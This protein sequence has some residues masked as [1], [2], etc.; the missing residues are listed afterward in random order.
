MVK[1]G[2]KFLVIASVSIGL[3]SVVVGSKAEDTP[4]SKPHYYDDAVT[5]PPDTPVVTKEDLPY[6]FND[7]NGTQPVYDDN[8]G[9]YLS[10]P[11]N[12]KTET[13]Y[14]PKTGNY[15]VTQ[16][17]GDMNY[18]PET[19]V[20]FQDYQDAL[21]KKAVKDHWKS[22]IKA[23]DLNNQN[24]KGIIPKLTV[25]SE[26]FD[27]IFGGNTVDIK[28]T[29]TAELIFALNRNK[30]LNPAIPQ[31]QQKVTN[32]DFN[33]RIQL[34]LIGKIGDKLKI[35]TNYNT[36]ASFDWENQM[37][38]E[39]TGYE[40]EII[41][42]IEAGNVSLPLN[43]TLITGS[44]S[45]FGVKMQLQFG[46]LTA[47]TIFSQQRGK[48][49]EV[50]VQGGSQIQN[51]TVTGD[52]YEVNKH[53]FLG[54][55]FRDNYDD[56]MKTLP[57][58]STPIIITKAEVYI[59][60]QTGS[61]ENVRS[62][63][64]F[65][66][67]GEDSA[68]ANPTMI[69]PNCQT[70]SNYLVVDSPGVV[71][72]NGANSLYSIISSTLA[73]A[74]MPA[75]TSTTT[76]QINSSL[77]SNAV[78]P[79]NCNSNSGFMESSRHYEYVTNARRLNPSEYSINTRLGFIS[80]NQSINNDVAVAVAYQYTYNGKTYQV[81][82][83]S[84]QFTTGPLYL[85]LLKG[86]LTNPKYIT[87]DL[88]MKNVYSIGA[89]NLNPQ[90]FK[91]DI[92]YNNIETGVDV[93]YIPA[94]AINGKLLLQVMDLDKLSVNGDKYSDGV[95]DFVKDYTINPV[96][97]RVYLSSKEPFG[98]NLREKF[99]ASDFPAA[100][101]YIFQYLYDS[102]RT[103]AQQFPERN[104]FKLKGQY[105]SA[106]G[107]EISL[108]ALNIPQGAVSVTANGQKLVENQDYTVD[109]TLGRVK[110]INESILNSGAN[111]KVSTESNSL[112]NV[113]QKSLFGTRLDYKVNK[114]LILG[115]TLL[116]LN[117]KPVTQK[118]T[119]GDE[120]VSN[121]IWG[122]DYN[123]R[124]DAP[125]L[126]RLVD[127]IPLI[128]TK[129]M[130][131]IVTQGEFAQLIPGNAKA[132]G[133]NGTS[134]VDDFEGS[135][136][137]IDIKSPQ[138]WT[139]AS[140]P[141][142]QA[143]LFPESVLSNTITT[144]L[145]RAQFNWYTIDN[146]FY[147][148]QNSSLKPANIPKETYANNFMRQVLETELFPSKTPP[149]GQPVVLSVLDLAF[150]P[151]ER[152]PY[153]YDAFP[154][155]G[156]SKGVASSGK[157]NNPET[158]W[159]GIMRRLETNDFQ[160]ANIEYVQFWM[161][162]PFNEDYDSTKTYE[163][164][165]KNNPPSGEM[166][167]NLG[168]I[169]EDVVKD[170]AMLYEN[171]LP[172]APT[173][174]NSGLATS[175]TNI[176]VYP[177]LTPSSNAFVNEVNDRPFQDAGYDGMIDTTE[178]RVFTNYLN[179]MNAATN[180]TVHAT[181][182]ADPSTD[183]YLHP[184]DASYDDFTVANGNALLGNTLHRYKKYNGAEGNSPTGSLATVNG[185]NVV[186]S[187]SPNIEDVNKDNT[188]NETEN[189]YQY[190]IKISPQDFQ[191]NKVGENFLV[192]VTQGTATIDGISKKVNW[193]QF[194]VPIAEYE[195]AVGSIEGFNSIRFM[196][197][198]MKG[199]DKPVICRLARFELVR[200]DWRRYQFDLQK[201]G[202][203]IANDDNTTSFDVSAV[204]LQEN[205]SKI[206]VNYVIPPGI[207]Q[208]QNVQTTNLVLQ[209]EQALSLRTCNLKDGDSRA[210]YKNIDLDVR[211]FKK[212]RMFMHA[213][214]L[215][216]DV[217]HDGDVTVFVRLGSD[218]NNNYYEYEIPV[219]LTP[220]GYYDP[221]DE[222]AKYN[223][224]PSENEFIMDFEEITGA[225]TERN[226]EIGLDLA[227]AQKPYTK[228]YGGY[229]ITVVGNP[230][231]ATVKSM[232]IGI[233][234]PKDNGALPKCVEVW[235]NELR[236]TDF[237]NKGG[238]ATTGRVQ[239]K[240]ADFGQISLS[241]LYS[242]PFF[243]SIEKKVSERSRETN[244]QWDAASTF[245]LGKF[246]PVKW[247]VNLPVYYAYGQT[248]V[249]PMYNPYDPDVLIDNKAIDP[250]LKKQIKANAQDITVRKGY[251]F[252]NIRVD[253]FKK[254]G[255]APMPWDV[256]NF[257]VTYAFNEVTRHNV[258]ID[259]SIVKSY[260]G[261][262][263]YNY[264]ITAKPWAPFKKSKNKIINNK[265]L[266]LVKDFNV[267]P[268]PSRLGFN[269]DINRSYSEL[270]NRDIT[271][272]YGGSNDV[273]T[274][275]Q[276][277]KTFNMTRN[278]D[279]QWSFTKNLKFDYTANNDS[280][281]LEPRDKIDTKEEKDS[282]MHNIKKL[283]ET[284]NYRHQANL[285]YQVPINKI[286]IFDF[287]NASVKYGATYTWTRRPFA[288]EEIGN[289]IQN[290]NTK[291]ANMAFTMP[292][293]YNK[294]PYF[295]KINTGG[296][297]NKPGAGGTK[298][299]S[300]T[301][302]D[303]AKKESSV[304]DIGEFIA[305][306]I[307]MIKQISL[308]YAQTN[309]T[310]L[311]GFM[312]SSQY[313]GM[314]NNSR[315]GWAPGFNFVSGSN[316]SILRKAINNDWLTKNPNQSLPYTTTQTS[317][318]TYRA[319]IEPHGSLKIELNGTKTH[320]Y[321]QSMFV[322]YDTS[323]TASDA[324]R[325]YLFETPTYSGNY[326]ISVFTLGRSFKDKGKGAESALFDEFLLIR[327]DVA[328]ELGAAN[329]NSTG[330]QTPSGLP[331]YVD[332]YSN[333]Q[334]DVLLGAFYQAYTGKKLKGVGSD[335]MFKQIPL[336]NWTISWDGLGKLKAMKKYFQ[337]ITI[338]HAYRSIYSLGGYSNNLLYVENGGT[339]VPV[340][341]TASGGT[342]NFNARYTIAGATITES[343]S[344]LIKFDFKFNKPGL[345]A[346]FEVKKDKTV[347]LNIT[348]P[349]II[350][351]KGQ[352]YIIGVGYRYPKLKINAV[353][354]KGKPLESDLNLKIDLSYRK[355]L[356]I[357]RKIVDEIST[358]TGGQNIISLKTA[359]DYQLTANINLRLFYD[360]IKTSPQTSNSFPTANTNAGFSLRFN[361][362]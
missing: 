164:M 291:S 283:G 114:D 81:G 89:Y 284:V 249:T 175:R 92:Y 360:W 264:A 4:L 316:D 116:R 324:N 129:E 362:Q 79:N 21:F 183:Q 228:Y 317:N 357:I 70:N 102:T 103:I 47:T 100:D 68:H 168:N 342:R 172:G 107:A 193:Y 247:K 2:F 85:K 40:D 241:A 192:N 289:T 275:A 14:N 56:W 155:N 218:F 279:L 127:K 108:N 10:N 274:K 134:Y 223:V 46:R 355:N 50:S 339:R 211:S 154:V 337:S 221:N 245:Q 84:D 115:G 257:S 202:E 348:G 278:Y 120:P 36:E 52:N 75:R 220:K 140:I 65:A 26:I 201:P 124:T 55:Y 162:D 12:I 142:G 137:L 321:S 323:A 304:K 292:T 346:N 121:T 171:G 353:K 319:N 5:L 281:I 308:T 336:P 246:F 188:L 38:L 239:A 1:G 69:D 128:N 86:T 64:G 74:I 265:W 157:L 261:A 356:T 173:G 259:H 340:D 104:R 28:P 335:R 184:K 189:Y 160:A 148:Q 136:S 295:R 6:Q 94:G 83:F 165:D 31:R 204:S 146:L 256:S 354:I 345:L 186:G 215:G 251:N 300:D 80:I 311:P 347:N 303:S 130:S 77:T 3:M 147:G 286:P 73:N 217:L 270:L 99:A 163:G 112:F 13:N 254:E 214:Q 306:G 250:E 23:E 315:Y 101:K 209:N 178:Q 266:A 229:N 227:A 334:Q 177:L 32:F 200:S 298:G 34:N 235:V 170:G 19:Y 35:T 327:P 150:Y 331:A 351:T 71:P 273:L 194:K 41:K 17:I 325:H 45:L 242:K 269:T 166:F 244:F 48:K 288:Q 179:N 262:L 277:N 149:N 312:P 25:N 67:L 133:K 180:S 198:F 224:W 57:V 152:G 37:K 18:R 169:S 359:I 253:G 234:N 126:T 22:K 280:R 226:S 314:D 182:F 111:I 122:L 132:I 118:V 53:Y 156:F 255:R 197:V 59:T 338:R 123:Y 263:S 233:R 78:A 352:E 322:R 110:I 236:L 95:Y 30:T 33:M 276:F 333:T 195:A 232:M 93:P 310:G 272:F 39:Y 203:Y 117:E 238:W 210:I 42:K 237:Q 230:N 141:Q 219:K 97:G 332:G 176:G 43:S 58:V 139:M 297:G 349:Q 313:M 260:R 91:C 282:I 8:S 358:P 318:I 98:N 271:S 27:R 66:D 54:H 252:S 309:G 161:M 320:G 185:V 119:I 187:N 326:S 87:W 167:I 158:R 16:K 212:M 267:T 240:L 307:M 294:I 208:Q 113:Q 330:L 76:N 290:T 329:P 222:T 131:T 144:G 361:L 51:F 296:G 302:K 350:E 49:Q 243:G 135:I 341:N 63:V 205:G 90:D 293:F 299:G 62:F 20:E 258:N 153:N 96:N 72:H 15:D 213:E 305:R 7:N 109:Y 88:M 206:P 125:F 248:R 181:A 61:T 207:N 231:L 82:E 285:N 44:Q 151:G 29:G 328:K 145:N 9:L 301:K 138:A 11:S 268:L 344:P 159:G 225:K 216:T 191:P 143:S 343:F 60:N 106:S 24:K 199:F 174:P 190:R 105:K 287:V 196:R